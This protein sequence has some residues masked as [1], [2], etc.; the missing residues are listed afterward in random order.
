MKKV[1][2]FII[3][4]LNFSE[5]SFCQADFRQGY[6]ITNSLDTIH[7]LI[8][9]RSNIRNAQN[10]LFKPSE[11]E[12]CT[13][14]A[15]KDIFGYRFIND[16]YYVSKEVIIDSTKEKRFLEF[17]LH[18]VIDLYCLPDLNG[19]HYFIQ[20]QGQ[21]ELIE[22]QQ[23]ESEVFKNSVKYTFVRKDYIGSLKTLF[24]DA[25]EIQNKIDYV[26]LSRRSL[27]NIS[28]DYHNQKCKGN[29]CIIYKKQL[30]KLKITIG[31]TGG[32]HISDIYLPAKGTYIG[33]WST[34]YYCNY[35]KLTRPLAGLYFNIP[36]AYN[37]KISIQYES[38]LSAMNIESS[39]Y[40]S[41]TSDQTYSINY[42]ILYNRFYFRYEIF[43]WKFRP[44]IL[45]GGSINHNFDIQYTNVNKLDNPFKNVIYY[46][47]SYGLGLAYKF[48]GEREIFCRII[49]NN[50][51]GIFD[52]LSAENIGFTMGLSLFTF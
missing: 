12:K 48:S 37:K 39:Y 31:I 49:N 52:N 51:F 3:I 40:P 43:K 38:L 45:L 36:F 50:E 23:T 9:Y 5:T 4:Q 6:I 32:I 14:Y 22:L 33:T 41:S 26:E 2:F 15:A 28:E 10:C 8:N 35:K 11:D 18:G 25:P 24:I 46:E 7:G 34:I 42:K 1:L 16:K 29:K 21:N 27:L 44:I 47:L 13:E 19:I 17:L 20:K 30:P